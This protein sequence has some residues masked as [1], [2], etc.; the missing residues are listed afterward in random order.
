MGKGI[1]TINQLIIENKFDNSIVVHLLTLI[2]KEIEV[3]IVSDKESFDV[4]KF[5]CD[6]AL[7]T[8]IDR[9]KSGSSII[10]NINRTLVI[11]QHASVTDELIEPFQQIFLLLTN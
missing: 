8:V 9:S 2:R 4:L 11:Y 10:A 3:L 6:W 1:D 7:H 5:Y